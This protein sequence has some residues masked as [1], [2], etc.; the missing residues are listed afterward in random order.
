M[1]KKTYLKRY[2]S[3]NVVIFTGGNKCDSGVIME[4]TQEAKQ[5]I[6]LIAGDTLA[7]FE[8]VAETARK[9]LHNSTGL[10]TNSLASV[11]TMTSALAIQTLRKISQAHIESYQKLVEEPAIARV[12]VADDT[13]K[14]RTYYICRTTPLSGIP[15]FA[16]YLAPVGRLASLPIGSKFALPNGTKVKILERARLRPFLTEKVWDSLDTIVEAIPFGPITIKS[17]RDLLKKFSEQIWTKTWSNECLPKK[18]KGQCNR[19]GS[20]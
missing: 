15:N 20:S 19:W 5:N 18:K 16:G 10:S 14:Q 6:D 2:F 1:S 9:E 7:L 4:L 3:N 11:N 8:K 13:G 17:L 12:V